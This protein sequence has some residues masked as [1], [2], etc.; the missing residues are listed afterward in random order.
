MFFKPYYLGCLAHASYLIGGDNGEAAVIDPRRDVG[1][2][3]AD[4]AA[5]GLTITHVIETHLHADFV[6]GHLELARKTGA[7]IYIGHKAGATFAHHPVHEGEQIALGDVTLRFL[8]TPG[9]TP[10]GVTI[11]ASVRGEERPRYVFTGDTLFIGDVGRPDLAG[12]KGFPPEEMARLLYRSLRD[13][14][15]R[16]PDTTEV[17]PAH[18]A[19]SSCGRA[20]SDARFSTIGM[21]K[22][23]NPALRSLAAEDEAGFIRY[24]TEGLSAA[25]RYFAHDVARNRAGALSVDEILASAQALSPEAVEALSEQEALVLDTRSVAEFGEGHIPGAVHV[26]LEGK[27]APWVGATL[28]PDRPILVVTAEGREPETMTRLA[29]IGYERL[30]GW[31]EGGMEAWKAAGGECVTVPQIDPESLRAAI[32][33]NRAAPVLDVRAR[34]E[35][36]EGHIAGATHIPL[37]ELEARIAEAPEGPLNVMCESGYRSS[38]ACSLLQRAGHTDVTNVVGGWAAWTGSVPPV[39]SSQRVSMHGLPAGRPGGE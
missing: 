21:E 4:A 14:V 35:W 38:I 23:T 1:E 22:A 34:R 12:S 15:L 32:A 17:W 13:K 2:Y 18:G 8:E 19:G 30:V 16:L 11:V 9:H 25:P 10:E 36:E 3:L 28:A 6:S 7:V 37:P 31:L 20:L 33:A 27:F 5:A 24:A 39:D 26:Q 29:R